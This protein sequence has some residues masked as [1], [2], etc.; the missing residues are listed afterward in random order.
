MSSIASQPLL[1]LKAARGRDVLEVDAAEARRDRLTVATISSGSRV[2]RQIGK[3]STPANS[4]NSI[5]LPSMTGIA[6]RGPMSPSPSTAVPSVTTA[7]VLRLIVYWNAL[8]GSSWIAR[9]TRA[10]PGVY[11]IE[12]SSRLRIGLLECN[13]ILPPD[14][15]HERAV[16]GVEHARAVD[17]VDG[18]GEP[19]PVRGVG[20]LDRD[21]ADRV[22]ALDLDEVDRA[23][24]AAG[25]ADG[26]GHLAEH[27]GP[28]VDLDPEVEAVLGARSAHDEAG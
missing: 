2:S 27:P 14:V 1:D 13:S 24:R 19:R 4:L 28:M 25:R 11:A 23:D 10:T 12:R 16:G 3:A 22:R 8:S 18:V 5:A 20:G 26:A 9:H 21:V 7:T 6:A 17:R 15:E